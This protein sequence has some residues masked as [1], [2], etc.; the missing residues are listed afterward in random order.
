MTETAIAVNFTATAVESTAKGYA[1]GL[2]HTLQQERDLWPEPQFTHAVCVLN[3]I[4]DVLNQ[5]SC[6]SDLHLPPSP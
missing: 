1:E 4:L 6:K 2:L 3:L 5:C